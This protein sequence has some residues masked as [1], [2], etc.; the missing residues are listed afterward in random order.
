MVEARY[1]RTIILV[2]GILFFAGCSAMKTGGQAVDI[3][4]AW[5]IEVIGELQVS[6]NNPASIQFSEDG[7]LGGNARC[8]RYFGQYVLHG[9]Q[10][11]IDERMGATKMMCGEQVLMEQEDKLLSILPGAATV[12]IENDLLIIR[13]QDGQL[14]I[15]ATRAQ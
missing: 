7:K 10:L 6:D 12:S 9:N 8:T 11:K 1:M 14:V 4:G 2:L 13:D 3:S 5:H 15:Q